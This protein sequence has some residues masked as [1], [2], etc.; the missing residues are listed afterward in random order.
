MRLPPEGHHPAG[1]TSA[2]RVRTSI[3]KTRQLGCANY[4]NR[5]RTDYFIDEAAE[6]NHVRDRLISVGEQNSVRAAQS[7]PRTEWWL[8]DLPAKRRALARIAA[9]ATGG[10]RMG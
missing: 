2:G 1:E 8:N 9:Q 10:S 7:R 4:Q 6:A 5:P 3:Y